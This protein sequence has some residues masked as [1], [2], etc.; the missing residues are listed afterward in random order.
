MPWMLRS[1]LVVLVLSFTTDPVAGAGGK[2]RSWREGTV[3]AIQRLVE[4]ADPG[5]KPEPV[6]GVD[7][8][9]DTPPGRVTPPY[10]A[11]SVRNARLWLY[12][13]EAEGRLYVGG[14]EEPGRTSFLRAL[15][16]G[17]KV[18]FAAGHGSLYV[19]DAAGKEHRLRE[20]TARADN[21]QKGK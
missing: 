13:I 17:N 8:M 16:V 1:A 12:A 3:M 7:V 5:R 19:R 9:T 20:L 11:Y 21:L 4:R 18:T 10:P 2:V 15:S 14:T 6:F